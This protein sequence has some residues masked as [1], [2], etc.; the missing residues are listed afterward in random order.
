M[1]VPSSW[2]A[3]AAREGYRQ[4]L[5]GW[6]GFSSRWAAPA[7][8]PERLTAILLEYEARRQT[9]RARQTRLKPPPGSERLR[10]YYRDR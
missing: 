6:D 10:H 1:H 8:S 4:E 7:P 9:L 5:S 3:P 2:Q